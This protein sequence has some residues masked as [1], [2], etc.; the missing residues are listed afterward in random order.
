ML[1]YHDGM[2]ERSTRAAQAQRAEVDD[3]VRSVAGNGGAAAEI[4]KATGLLDSGAFTRTEFDAIKQKALATASG[5]EEQRWKKSDQSTTRSWP[6]PAAGFGG[7]SRL[8]SA[9]SSSRG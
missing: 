2:A 7:S 5:R 3:Y 4:E 8:R 6:S 1:A 9:S